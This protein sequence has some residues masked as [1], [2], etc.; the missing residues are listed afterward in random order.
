MNLKTTLGLVLVAVAGG[1]LWWFDAKLPV[2]LSVT[3]PAPPPTASETVRILGE[4]ITGDKLTRIE[5]KQG[6]QVLIL[7]KENG[8]WTLPGKWP[9]RT[10]EVN[11]LVALLTGLQSRF[12][13]VAV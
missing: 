12:A 9:T 11:Q 7:Q 8:T 3:P 10:A 1:A 2:S 4:E 5:M 6:D 13:P